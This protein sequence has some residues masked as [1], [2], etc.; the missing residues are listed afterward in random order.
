[1]RCMYIPPVFLMT[2]FTFISLSAVGLSPVFFAL[3]SAKSA[4]H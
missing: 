3:V 1:M 2:V 4:N